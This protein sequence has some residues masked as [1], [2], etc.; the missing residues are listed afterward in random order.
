LGIGYFDFLGQTFQ[1]AVNQCLAES[2]M[3]LLKRDR[4]AGGGRRIKVKEFDCKSDFSFEKIKYESENFTIPVVCKGLL[5]NNTCRNWSL[6]NFLDRTRDSEVSRGYM[7]DPIDSNRRAFIAHEYPTVMGKTKDMYTRMKNGEPIYISFDN[8]YL[9]LRHPEIVNEMELQ[10]YFPGKKFL[11]NTLFIS[12]FQHKSL[13]SP[14]HAAPQDNFFFQC[15]GRKHW[16]YIEPKDM[17]Y[18]G[19]YLSRGVTFSSNFVD[20]T[21]IV[22]RVNIYE[23]VVEEGDLMYNPPFWLHAVGTMPGETISVAN[24]IWQTLMPPP[25]N[26]FIDIMYKLNFPIFIATIIY[27]RIVDK[28]GVNSITIN[29]KAKKLKHVDELGGGLLEIAD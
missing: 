15:K 18:V 17:T 6:T 5:L 28:E 7:L 27:S 9:T 26:L 24:R 8:H 29:D 21:E 3:Y 25:N 4:P 16:F 20:E 14:F 10:K 12:N 1:V 23:A 19:S 22:D 13:G 2:S 11:L